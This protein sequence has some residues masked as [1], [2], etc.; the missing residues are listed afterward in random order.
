MRILAFS[1]SNS[2]SS[3]NQELIEHVAG[4]L[5]TQVD[6]L[7]LRNYEIPMYGIDEENSNGFPIGLQA[8]FKTFKSYDAYI[9]S[10][11]EHNGNFP[12][13]FKNTI[14]WFS[15]M[16]RDFFEGKPV[17]LLSASPGK[18]GGSSVL[19]IAEQSFLYF[20]GKVLG[21][22]SLPEFHAYR[23]NGKINI[24]GTTLGTELKEIL[25]GYEQ[26]LPR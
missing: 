20:G 10:I 8:L 11:P 6:V 24:E 26:S 23:S 13:F 9:I 22:F 2:A 14:D 1:G 16:E 12:A 3:I 5:R 7:D 19:G 21:R 17:L 15:R 4:L 18:E 25:Y